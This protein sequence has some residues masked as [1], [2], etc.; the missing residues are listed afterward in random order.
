MTN[1]FYCYRLLLPLIV[2]FARA[3]RARFTASLRLA[4]FFSVDFCEEW[5]AERTRRV[6]RYVRNAGT[7]TERTRSVREG[8]RGF[9][10][11]GFE[12]EED[13]RSLRSRCDF[14]GSN[15][16]GDYTLRV[17]RRDETRRFGRG[18]GKIRRDRDLNPEPRKGTRF[19]GVRFAIRPS[20]P[21][22]F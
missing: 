14:Q 20:R 6:K 5:C 16:C 13:G 19:P 18:I 2:A 7:G 21:V 15:P 10:A 8:R 9:A 17:T 11:P 12:P 3:K 1:G 4:G 22:E